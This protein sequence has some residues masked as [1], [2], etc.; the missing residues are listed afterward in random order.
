MSKTS[1]EDQKKLMGISINENALFS[2]PQTPVTLIKKIE[3]MR[4]HS[5]NIQHYMELANRGFKNI[6]SKLKNFETT[7]LESP[8]VLSGESKS[9]MNVIRQNMAF[10]DEAQ[11]RA[12]NLLRSVD[13]LI[14]NSS[15]WSVN[16]QN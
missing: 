7:A 6:S 1:L 14:S 3:E 9:L 13:Y 16:G 11:D 4:V 15:Q 5:Q 2:S 8:D 12:N 10:I